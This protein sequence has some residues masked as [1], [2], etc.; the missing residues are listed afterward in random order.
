MLSRKRPNAET[1]FEQGGIVRQIVDQIDKEKQKTA[2]IDIS[3]NP[4]SRELFYRVLAE[5]EVELDKASPDRTYLNKIIRDLRRN[6]FGS[7]NNSPSLNGLIFDVSGSDITLDLH[8]GI[9]DSLKDRLQAVSVSSGFNMGALPIVDLGCG[10]H[11]Y[12]PYS[13]LKE[14]FPDSKLVGVDLDPA[15]IIY[16]KLVAKGLPPQKLG[17]VVPQWAHVANRPD[18]VLLDSYVCAQLEQLPFPDNYSGFMVIESAL[19]DAFEVDDYGNP[20]LS[21]V[22]THVPSVFSEINRVLAEGGCLDDS[23]MSFGADTSFFRKV[24]GKLIPWRK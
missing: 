24:D 17:F 2:L 5:I 19:E 6:F 20:D 8:E 22:R 16:R 13:V 9:L 7:V 4:E 3:P 11:N 15:N 21:H 18:D 12:V 14:K 23:S 10:M 1:S